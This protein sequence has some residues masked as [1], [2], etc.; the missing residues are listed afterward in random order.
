M[1]A[2]LTETVAPAVETK[3]EPAF[4]A[5]QRQAARDVSEAAVLWRLFL[6]LG[7]LDIR[8]RYRG[9]LLGPFWLTLSTAVMVGAL[10]VLYSTLFKTNLHDYMPFLALSLVLWNSFIASI[11]SDACLAFLQA[12]GTIRSMRMPFTLHA[13]RVVVRNLI[14]LAHNIPIILGVFA[15]FDVWPGWGA[16]IAIPGLLL[17]IAD[18]LAACLLLGTFCARFRDIPPIVASIMQI[19]FFISPIIW[20]PELVKNA[21]W[22]PLNPFFSLLEIVRL[23]LL[24]GTPSAIIWIS[25]IGYSLL[26]AAA[27]WL[28]F[29]RVRA[30][31]AFW[32]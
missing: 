16:L 20:K 15:I 7:W 5:R 10:G 26:L 14:V 23:P 24:G 8:L 31:L 25:A 9:S 28:L 13:A 11:V 22:M 17:W 18:S 30:R 21:A 27:G 19:A 29:A 1:T 4:T 3:P 2:V 6:R 12:E 32:V